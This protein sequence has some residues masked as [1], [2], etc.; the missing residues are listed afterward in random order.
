MRRDH[1]EVAVIWYDVA[2]IQLE[3]GN[4]EFA[5]QFYDETLHIEE[6]ALDPHHID[7]VMI[8]VQHL[9][10]VHQQRGELAEATWIL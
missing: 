9:G 10:M 1:R 3:G 7:G 4:E 8:T 6:M 5:V 2:T